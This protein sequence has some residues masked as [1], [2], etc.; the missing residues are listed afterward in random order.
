MAYLSPDAYQMAH[1]WTYLINIEIGEIN[2]PLLST[3]IFVFFLLRLLQV[4]EVESRQCINLRVE[5][6]ERSIG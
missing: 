6:R 2:D 1:S 5:N 3:L 4:D